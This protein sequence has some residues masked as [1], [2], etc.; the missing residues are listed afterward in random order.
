M[1]LGKFNE[2]TEESSSESLV[3]ENFDQNHSKNKK[4][5]SI[6]NHKPFRKS[7]PV[8]SFWKLS[9]KF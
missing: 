6:V 3:C 5:K 4:G 8:I 9:L 2:M 7:Y 1:F